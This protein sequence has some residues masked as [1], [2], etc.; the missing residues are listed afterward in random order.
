MSLDLEQDRQGAGRVRPAPSAAIRWDPLF[1]C[2]CTF[3]I[4]CSKVVRKLRVDL[5]LVGGAAARLDGHL[6]EPASTHE[7]FEGILRI[8]RIARLAQRLPPGP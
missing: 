2:F 7:F 4:C 1:L 6:T 3:C 5:P 8:S